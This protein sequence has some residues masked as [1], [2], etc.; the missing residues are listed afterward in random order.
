MTKISQIDQRRIK[1]RE[2]Y[3]KQSFPSTPFTCKGCGGFH[4][5]ILEFHFSDKKKDVTLLETINKGFTVK[6]VQG[7]IDTC[8]IL[9][10]NCHKKL[11]WEEKT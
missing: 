5:A 11:H 6:K 8:R 1:L 9:C 3:A 4:L 2:F 10:A 7:I